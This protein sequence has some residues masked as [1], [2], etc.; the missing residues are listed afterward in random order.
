MSSLHFRLS[1]LIC[2]YCRSYV[3]VLPII[4]HQN[5]AA[6]ITCPIWQPVYTCYVYVKAGINYE[7][8]I[9]S[10]RINIFFIS[11]E[12]PITVCLNRNKS[13]LCTSSK[14][15]QKVGFVKSR[16]CRQCGVV[17]I[18]FRSS[19]FSNWCVDFLI[20]ALWKERNTK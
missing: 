13:I 3:I 17:Q 20:W 1:K 12:F 16:N 14:L 2:K 10:I 7:N 5:V 8:I 6:H 9:N 19:A 4:H 15:Q 11:N 18:V